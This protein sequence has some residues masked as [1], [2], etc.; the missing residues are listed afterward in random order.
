MATM[1]D[2]I[3]S[4]VER[5]RRFHEHQKSRRFGFLVR[6]LTLLLG[7]TVLIVG[8]LT[9]PLPGQGWLTTFVG[10]GI[11]SLEQH[12]AHRL[13]EWGVERYD[14]FFAWFARQSA[15][16]RIMLIVLLIAVIWAIFG[17]GVYLFWRSGGFATFGWS[18][19]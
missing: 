4:R 9:I 7:W 18:P 12:W 2:S 11:L 19:A 5:L 6:P 14:R 1:R 15:G 10:V 13:L 3:S 17:V 8:V 16:V